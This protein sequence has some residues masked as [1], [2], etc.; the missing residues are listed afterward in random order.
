[1]TFLG[2]IKNSFKRVLVVDTE[3]R[4]DE[5]MSIPQHVVCFVYQDV[6]TGEVYKYWE[7]ENLSLGRGHFDYEDCLI[8]SYNAV[9]E[10]GCYLN[11]LHGIPRN[12]WDVYVENA[13]LYKSIRTGKGALKLLT[14]AE[15]YGVKDVMTKEY[16]T[17]CLELI[18]NNTSYDL[19]QQKQILN[20]C[21]EDVRITADVFIKQV[22]DIQDKLNLEYKDYP[23]ELQQ[24]M[25]RGYSQGCVAK[26]QKNGIPIDLALVNRFNKNWD[27]V[28]DKLIKTYN[29]SINVFDEDNTL[30]DDKF[31]ALVIREGLTFRWPKL[32][33][34]KYK[35]DKKTISR[36]AKFNDKI[37]TFQQIKSYLNMSRLT[38]YEP[39]L[40][41]RVRSS[42]NMFGTITGRTSPS[43]A[44]YPL[45]A[46]RWF[47]NMIKPSWGNDLYYLDYKS[48]E[49]AIMGYLSGDQNLIDAYRTGD[50]YIHTG[51]LCGVLPDYAT[52]ITHPKE[53]NMFKILYLANSYGQGAYAVSK[54]LGI[55]LSKAKELLRAFKETYKVY[56]KWSEQII[57]AGLFNKFLTTSMG[58]QRRLFNVAD[59]IRDGKVRNIY[60][61]LHNWPVQSHGGE[62]LRMALIDLTDAHFEI[63]ALVHD[64]VLIQIPKSESLDRLEEAKKIMVDA[65]IKVVGGPISVSHETITTN[66]KQKKDIQK[67]FTDIMTEMDRYEKSKTY[68]TLT[69]TYDTLAVPPYIINSSIK[70]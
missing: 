38:A 47:R 13:R 16:K 4:F 49:P 17:E 31:D 37:K 58:W 19:D 61:S 55:S 39:G 18:I 41:G 62:V 29:K 57:D 14:T 54:Q 21:A 6:F 59:K 65:S 45:N 34:G 66:W 69:S 43:T 32:N 56:F 53:R 36:F 7:S 33:S 3:F 15:C 5:S 10:N 11:L 35:K 24:I 50:I 63:N 23:R 52:D 60:N 40:D 2:Y 8:I 67:M 48:Q 42:I 22:E 68:D 64:A 26:V 20:Y 70:Y 9:A 1:M 30:L 27:G 44:K 12:Q 25:R 46:G 28:K 51:K